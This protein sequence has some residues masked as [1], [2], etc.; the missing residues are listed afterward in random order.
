MSIRSL[1]GRVTCWYVGLLAAAL[2]VFGACLYFAFQ[3]YLDTTF[4]QSLAG[5]ARGVAQ[6]FVSEVESKGTNWLSQELSEEYPPESVEHYIRISRLGPGGD[7]NLIYQSA[8]VGDL[9]LAAPQLTPSSYLRHLHLR[10]V[11]G[12]S[13]QKIVFYSFLYTSPSGTQYLIE[14]GASHG[15]VEQLLRKLLAILLLVTPLVLLAAAVGGYLMMSQ[16]LKPV[17]SLT[18]KAER[19]GIGELGERLPV[20]QTGDELERLSLS[21]NRMISRLEEA[22]AH[23]RRFSADVSHELRTP[24]TILRGELEHVIQ[25]RSAGPDI[26]ES[27]GSALEEIERLARIVESLLTISH[28]DSGGAGIEFSRF[29]LQELVKTTA[30]QMRLLADEKRII[31]SSHC[32]EPVYSHGD[33]S[34]IKQILVNLLDNAIKYSRQGGHIVTSVK[35]EGNTAVLTVSDDGVGIPADALP[36]VFDRFYRAEKARTRGTA[37]AG[38]G[39]SIVQAICRAHGGTVSVTSTEGKGTGVQVRL[40]GADLASAPVAQE[41][42][43]MIR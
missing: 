28:L 26:A 36:H 17:V 22:L 39:L 3:R 33:K 15:W 42:Q 35:A 27:V 6:T 21:L 23:N 19:I 18:L 24:L 8:N 32:S 43:A 37:G 14:T 10:I 29:D 12:N 11:S 25:M 20:I 4:E 30:E 16:P 40:P 7:Y 2:L 38:L 5:E 1:R 31:M 13:D 34:R 41:Q 9:S